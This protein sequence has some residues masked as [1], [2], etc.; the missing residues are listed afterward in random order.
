MTVDAIGA[1][2]PKVGGA[3]PINRLVWRMPWIRSVLLL[4]PPLVWFV[5]IYLA[6]LVLLLIT[7]FWTTDSFTTKIVQAWNLDNFR[8]I[9]TD[10]AYRLII[11][12]TVLL[13]TLVTLTDAVIAFPFAYYMARVATRRTES[14]AEFIYAR[15]LT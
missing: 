1:P 5:A 4:I 6:A 2:R 14:R 9:L 3:S 7:A 13:A 12:R 15:S 10:P 11:G 8:I